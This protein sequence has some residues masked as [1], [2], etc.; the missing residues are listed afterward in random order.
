MVCNG[1]LVPNRHVEL[2]ENLYR[3]MFIPT[4]KAN[5]A[6]NVAFNLEKIPGQCLNISLCLCD[7]F[8]MTFDLGVIYSASLYNLG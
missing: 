6:I 5:H 3:F 8:K 1:D 2:S 7:G 4:V